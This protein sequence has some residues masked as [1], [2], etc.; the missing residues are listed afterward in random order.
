MS[1]K[2]NSSNNN[3]SQIEIALVLSTDLIIPRPSSI[4]ISPL[5]SVAAITLLPS[6]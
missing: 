5:P 3:R 6:A 2:G 1:R 4:T